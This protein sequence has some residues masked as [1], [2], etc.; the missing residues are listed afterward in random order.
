MWPLLLVSGFLGF[1]IVGALGVGWGVGVAAYADRHI[2]WQALIGTRYFSDCWQ[3]LR[4]SLPLVIRNNLFIFISHIVGT[5]TGFLLVRNLD[6]GTSPPP[7]M[8]P[9]LIVLAVV[10]FTG[11]NAL[12]VQNLL[13]NRWGETHIH[14]LLAS[15]LL[16]FNWQES[17]ILVRWGY[18]L[19]R[20]PLQRLSSV[21]VSLALFAVILMAVFVP[22]LGTAVA[23]V[24]L[25]LFPLASSLFYV[26]F[27]DIY[28]GVAENIPV[29]SEKRVVVSVPD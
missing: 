19:N 10:F 4:R 15:V 26:S 25:I 22:L 8:N 9:V 23:A 1:L 17:R 18:L 12:L 11:G 21:G 5:G 13:A 28:L 29:R 24:G 6:F 20:E 3:Y 27:R 14:Y 7:P 2:S 16:G